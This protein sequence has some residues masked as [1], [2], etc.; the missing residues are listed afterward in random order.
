MKA[1]IGFLFHLACQKDLIARKGCKKLHLQQRLGKIY[2]LMLIVGDLWSWAVGS[3][4]FISFPKG[5]G[6]NLGMWDVILGF[7]S[8]KYSVSCDEG[9]LIRVSAEDPLDPYVTNVC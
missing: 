5:H 6:S 2:P 1:S 7:M 3:F 9:Q 4:M 8:L